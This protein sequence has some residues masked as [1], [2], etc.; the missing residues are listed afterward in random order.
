[1]SV[2]LEE[3]SVGSR[4]QSSA[5]ERLRTSSAAV[6]LSF[7]WFG[8]RK[9]LTSQQK[10]Q[11]ADAFGA[12]EQYLSAGK[13]LLDTRHPAFKEVTGIKSRK[14]GLWK[15]LTLPYPESGIRLI[16]QDRIDS[17]NHQMQQLRGELE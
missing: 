12:E 10:A 15:G 1:M 13:K 8:T 14:T 4:H 5:A 9:S 7:T 2:T 17:F 16:R 11:A 3:P 6:R